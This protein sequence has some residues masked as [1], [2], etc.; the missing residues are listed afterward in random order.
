MSERKIDPA[1]APSWKS[2][3]TARETL[4][5]LWKYMDANHHFGAVDPE[6]KYCVRYFL[7]R[8]EHVPETADGRWELFSSMPRVG[9]VNEQIAEAVNRAIALTV[10]HGFDGT[11][12]ESVWAGISHI[13]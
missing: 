5:G 7:C 2:F 13:Y 8:F 9:E 10:Q 3:S 1:P 12:L 11:A 6:P 4:E